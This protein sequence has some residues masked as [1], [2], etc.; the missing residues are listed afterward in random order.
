MLC[1]VNNSVYDDFPT[2]GSTKD[3][4][5]YTYIGA[6]VGHRNGER[7]AITDCNPL[8]KRDRKLNQ[9]A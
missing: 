4:R 8:K 2:G 1:S 5:V 3:E 9:N 6:D 7:S